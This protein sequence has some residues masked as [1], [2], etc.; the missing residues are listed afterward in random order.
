MTTLVVLAV[1]W[2][3]MLAGFLALMIYR[4]HLTNMETDQ[5]FLSDTSGTAAVHQEQD[6]IIH[7]VQALAP[8]LKTT[9]IALAVVS[10]AIAVLW[11][12]QVLLPQ[13]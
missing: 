11:V 3:V 7:R 6:L 5:L 13:F 1:L 10:I 4:S 2:G 12:R 8:V 9:G